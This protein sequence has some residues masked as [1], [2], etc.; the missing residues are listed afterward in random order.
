MFVTN[1]SVHVPQ[2]KHLNVTYNT[3]TYIKQN[4]GKQ[5]LNTN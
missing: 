4:L 1:F 2:N 5:K 3:F